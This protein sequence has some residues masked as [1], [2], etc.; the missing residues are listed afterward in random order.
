MLEE[1][2]LP[3]C[4]HLEHLGSHTTSQDTLGTFDQEGAV[5]VTKDRKQNGTSLIYYFVHLQKL[6]ERTYRICWVLFG[7]GDTM[8]RKKR[9]G[10]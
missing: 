2:C 8:G 6:T 10:P 5:L 1:L 9:H 7:A 4:A 3:R